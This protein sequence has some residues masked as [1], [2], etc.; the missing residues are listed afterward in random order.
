MVSVSSFSIASCDILSAAGYYWY[1]RLEKEGEPGKLC[2]FYEVWGNGDDVAFFRHGEIGCKAEA[3]S[4]RN[5]GHVRSSLSNSLLMGWELNTDAIKRVDPVEVRAFRKDH[6]PHHLSE[7]PAPFPPEPEEA[8][9]E[10]PTKTP[11]RSIKD[12][13]RSRQRKADW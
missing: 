9:K 8:P 4:A 11:Q 10:E 5:W 7:Y 12:L 13:E 6:R 1:I 3:L 2:K